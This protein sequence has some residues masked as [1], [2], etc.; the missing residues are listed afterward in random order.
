MNIFVI[1]PSPQ[2]SAAY[3]DDKRV[4]KMVLESAQILSTIMWHYQGSAPYKR[5]HHNHPCVL[6]AQTNRSNYLWLYQHFVALCNEYTQR[7]GKIHRCQQYQKLFEFFAV[8][9]PEGIQTPFANVTFWPDNTTESIFVL[10]Q[11]TLQE[12]WM[13]D[14]RKPSW[15]GKTDG[16]PF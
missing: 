1:S 7:Y 9:V 8:S 14:K 4:V 11:K 13:A 15:Y 5:T 12:K 3:L 16:A 10:Y 2:A 6:W